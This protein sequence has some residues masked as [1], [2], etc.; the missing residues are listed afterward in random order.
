EAV[1]EGEKSE[2]LTQIHLANVDG[3]DALQ[4]TFSDKLSDHPHWSPD[5]EWVAFTSSRS[6]KDNIWLIRVRGGEA[7][8]LTDVKSGVGSF[9]W[10]PDGKAIAFTATDA[11]S[12][13]EEKATK[14]KNDARV[15]DE[16]I[17][18]SHLFVIPVDKDSKGKREARQ[19]TKGNLHVGTIFGPDS[20][21]W[22][23]NGK[24]IVFTHTRTPKADD[25]TSADISLVDV[26]N[27]TI[28]PLVTTKA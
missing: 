17:K 19:L 24:T 21:D 26:A 8:Q 1:M 20:F 18:M 11:P 12:A 28:R 25:W 6:G 13:E 4:L 3:S 22:S 23:P 7:Q 2:H 10:S 14:E 27:A 15:V 5:G 9:K 16:N